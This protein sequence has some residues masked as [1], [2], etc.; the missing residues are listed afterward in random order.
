M[1]SIEPKDVV[2]EQTR[3]WG[4]NEVNPDYKLADSYQRSK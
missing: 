3:M 4:R 1:K 2:E